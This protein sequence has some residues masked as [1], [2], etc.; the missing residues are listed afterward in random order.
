MIIP[1]LFDEPYAPRNLSY[2]A[3]ANASFL[4]Y[5]V[6]LEDI[7]YTE[8][9]ADIFTNISSP[10]RF[11]FTVRAS[12]TRQ[13]IVISSSQSCDFS[14]YDEPHDTVQNFSCSK[15][16]S[17]IA[18]I[19]ELYVE[20]HKFFFYRLKTKY[21]TEHSGVLWLLANSLTHSFLDAF[22]DFSS[23]NNLGPTHFILESFSASVVSGEESISPTDLKVSRIPSPLLCAIFHRIVSCCSSQMAGLPCSVCFQ[24]TNVVLS[25]FPRYVKPS[26][27]QLLVV[28]YNPQVLNTNV[29]PEPRTV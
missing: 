13:H 19:R 15:S 9:V 23:D 25:Q 11:S 3:L 10:F 6:L 7:Y 1:P 8:R 28:E 2:P 16:F 27:Y 4:A 20:M 17:S 12:L 22:E 18:P 29:E 14:C 21:F 24:R 26:Q 5:L